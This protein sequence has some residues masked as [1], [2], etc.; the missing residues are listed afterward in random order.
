MT[1]ASATTHV[2][3]RLIDPLLVRTSEFATLHETLLVTAVTTVLVIRTQ[4]WLTNYPQ[5]G[6]G[7]LHIAHL[8]YGGF[9]MLAAIALT[10]TFLG[11]SVR[12]R[13]AIVGGVGFGF[14]IDELGKFITA[15]NNYF[16]KPAA[17]AIYVVFVT[18]FLLARWAQ[19][20]QGFSS[21]EYVANALELV[22]EAVRHE[23][24]EDER[25]RALELLDRADQDDPLV[26]PLRALLAQVATIPRRAPSRVT[27]WL[28]RLHERGERIAAA[29]RFP[30]TLIALFAVWAL[31]SA[32]AAFELTL[33]VGLDLG[34]AHPGFVSDQL[35]NLRLQN[36]LS[37]GSS[38]VSAVLVGVGIV[39]LRAGDRVAC[40]RW[41]ERALLVSIFVTEV[42]NFVESQMGAVFGLAIAL[43]L[44]AGVRQLLASATRMQSGSA[45]P[46]D[47]AAAPAAVP[48]APPG[49]AI[50]LR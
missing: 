35:G 25:R 48:T 29:P 9:F 13:A 42:F 2:R 10:L 6:G 12:H 27:R 38:L 17:G 22:G 37:M 47:A 46:V 20:R 15:D 24:D 32:L 28:T 31:L 14:F 30:A 45:G 23:L 4:L 11:R 44:L 34:G 39:R 19:R 33:S 18:L 7:G 26:T 41:F 16:Y 5:L 40:M 3:R 49:A 43:L 1:R 50:G 8:L 21:R 36:F